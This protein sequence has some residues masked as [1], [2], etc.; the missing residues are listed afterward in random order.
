M[1]L[2]RKMYDKNVLSE[3]TYGIE[4]LTLNN[5]D[6]KQNKS[7]TKKYGK[8]GVRLIPKRLVN[9]EVLRR[10]PIHHKDSKY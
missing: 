2:K 6:C 8:R 9:T 5:E 7:N 10:V 4:T 3:L 1:C